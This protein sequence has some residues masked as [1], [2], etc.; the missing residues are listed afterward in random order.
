MSAASTLR[1]EP[2][3]PPGQRPSDSLLQSLMRWLPGEAAAPWAAEAH[4]RSASLLP[5][6]RA[7]FEACLSG[8][9]EADELLRSIR[10]GRSLDD[11][12]HLRTGLYTAVARAHSQHEAEARLARLN[13][14]FRRSIPN[15]AAIAAVM[16][17]TPH[18]RQ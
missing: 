4:L 7:E 2:V 6:V 1:G 10:R 12:W 5:Q 11:L 9:Q 15:A 16:A 17:A 18:R 14:H 13:Q 8:V 3:Q